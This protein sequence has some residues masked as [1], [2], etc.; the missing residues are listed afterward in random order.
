MSLMLVAIFSLKGQNKFQVG[1]QYSSSYL[2]AIS[3][4]CALF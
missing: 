1:L 3:V 2:L 4:G